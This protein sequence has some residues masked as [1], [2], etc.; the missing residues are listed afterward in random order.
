MG[1]RLEDDILFGCVLI[2]QA[3]AFTISILFS[4]ILFSSFIDHSIFE[5]L[6]KWFWVL[7]GIQII[8]IGLQIYAIITFGFRKSFTFLQLVLSGRGGRVGR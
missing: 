5:T 4:C 3:I 1:Y 8:Y 6:G 2:L 7:I